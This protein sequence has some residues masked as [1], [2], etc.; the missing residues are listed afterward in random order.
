MFHETPTL[1]PVGI[2]ALAEAIRDET[3]VDLRVVDRGTIERVQIRAFN[4][5]RDRDEIVIVQKWSDGDDVRSSELTFN[6]EDLRWL[7]ET[8]VALCDVKPIQEPAVE[9]AGAF[10]T[11]IVNEII[12]TVAY[13][14][15]GVSEQD[16]RS[17]S[18]S[19]GD[20]VR[21]RQEAMWLAYE[22]TD[23]SP[24]DIAIKHFGYLSDQPMLTIQGKLRAAIASCSGVHY[25][26]N[27]T[28]WLKRVK[29]TMALI[30][31][32]KGVRYRRTDDTPWKR[33]L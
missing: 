5:H 31:D 25:N 9:N 30:D 11:H 1:E 4:I 20:S 15:E 24:K 18:R 19:N 28:A 13:L 23:L 8:Q 2:A 6:A 27:P 7:R 32:T 3:W 14:T 12:R 29:V 16:L 10:S 22:M 17:G 33:L 26:E 21:P